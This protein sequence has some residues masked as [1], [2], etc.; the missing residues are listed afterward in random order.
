MTSIKIDGAEVLWA[1]VRDP[2]PAGL[3]GRQWLVAPPA[4][5]E[6]Y[7]VLTSEFESGRSRYWD[8]GLSPDDSVQAAAAALGRTRGWW[9]VRSAVEVGPDVSRETAAALAALGVRYDVLEAAVEESPDDEAGVEEEE[10]RVTLDEL[11]LAEE[12]RTF[13]HSSPVGTRLALMMGAFESHLS[14]RLVEGESLP[15]LAWCARCCEPLWAEDAEAWQD[16]PCC[17]ACYDDLDECADCDTRYITGYGVHVIG[18]DDDRRDVCQTCVEQYPWCDRCEARMHADATHNHGG[19]DCESPAPTFRIRNNGHGML[20]QDETVTV[21]LPG[22]VISQEGLQEMA[23]LLRQRSGWLDET[24]RDSTSLE[25]RERAAAMYGLSGK[26]YELD[27]E[28]TTKRGNFTKRLSRLAYQDHQLK[29]PPDLVS[30]IG[31][32]FSAHAQPVDVQIAVTRDLNLDPEDFAHEESC[33]WGSYF[34]S[35]CA[36]KS[37]GGF[38]LRSFVTHEG[39]HGPWVEVDGRAWV[40]PVRRHLDLDRLVPTFDTEQPDGF[41][42]FNGYEELGGYKGARTMAYLSGWTYRKVQFSASPMYV[43]SDSGYLVGPE[44]LIE[45]FARDG[46]QLELDAHSD[47]YEREQETTITA[48]TEKETVNV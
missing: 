13:L 16:N 12:W 18:A 47:L 2:A 39:I 3:H 6:L 44:D 1:E 10:E 4:E 36:L 31:N 40:L 35:R 29:L 48:T 32:I 37:N 38:G 46:I 20:R 24:S 9:I 23:R 34:T 22:G 19:C 17:S 11:D 26:V 25:E 21:T 15:D 27:P 7:C 42:V 30:E 43:N 8:V 33:W 41:V 28:W 5:P 45:R 14:G